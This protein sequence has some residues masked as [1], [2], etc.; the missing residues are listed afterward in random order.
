M[1]L[2]GIQWTNWSANPLKLELPN[3]ARV[4]ACVK[5]SP[6]CLSCYAESVTRRWWKR[7]WGPFPGYVKALLRIGKPVLIEDEL[8]AVLRLSD[9]IREDKA[10]PAINKIFWNDVTD[11]YL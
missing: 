1:N 11:E 9:R 3:G 4:N 2:T 7:K 8:K 5:I 6:G 10:D